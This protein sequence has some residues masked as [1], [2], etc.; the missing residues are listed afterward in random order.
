VVASAGGLATDIQAQISTFPHLQ[1]FD[2]VQAGILPTGWS[3]TRNVSPDTI[4]FRVSL[5]NP[6][7]PPHA[8]GS[9]NARV[10]Q[11]LIS[12]L[13]D[14]SLVAPDTLSFRIVRSST[15]TARMLV[16]ASI[17]SGITYA[18]QL[19]DSLRHPGVTGYVPVKL[20]LPSVL[21]SQS[22]VRF[23]WRIVGDPAAGSTA[24][25]RMDDI[26]VTARASDDLE[27]D[28]VRF[29]P[30]LPTEG[31][32]MTAIAKI[33]NLGLRSAQNF[34]AEFY[35]DANN[36]SLPQPVELRSVT[37]SSGSVAGG[38]SVELSGGLGIVAAG[39]HLAIVRLVYP[40][41]QNP[42]NNLGRGWLAVGYR[43]GSIVVNEIMYA[44]I[45]PEP[46]WL[47]L[48]NTRA[49]SISLR[50]WFIADSS[51][52][53]RR[54]TTQDITIPPGGYAVLTGNPASLLNIHP[55][56]PAVI[57]GVGSFP[58]L[59]NSG[60]AVILY[61]SRS[62]A[63]D[64][65]RYLPTW[66]GNAG[67]R[68]LERIDPVAPSVQQSNWGSC[69]LAERSTP[70]LRNSLTRKDSDL[71]V[72][73]LRFAPALPVVGESV[74]VSV[75]VRN[76]GRESI[77]NFLVQ[78][79]ADLNTDSL[80][81][82]EELIGSTQNAFPLPPLDSVG[83][84]FSVGTLAA[85]TR[86]FIG[87]VAFAGDEDTTNNTQPARLIVGYPAGAVRIN[88]I[89]YAPAAGVPEWVELFN[90]ST[91]SVELTRWILGNRSQSSRYE[92]G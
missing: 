75:Q 27:L 63:M 21:S 53:Q 15:H 89:M 6:F 30:S 22:S 29:H 11:S 73:T 91:D 12:P 44:P 32:S 81:Q 26:L 92:I 71:A 52:T 56:I 23:R 35:V 38:D 25:L 46:E 83:Y 72:D 1:N 59:N 77:P 4:D 50:N 9:T 43:P 70:G 58:S 3:S 69:R 90:A 33:R 17:D 54:I 2:S 87:R 10:S 68:S 34:A 60:D 8:V 47:E 74:T 16:E 88:E 66:G 28:S 84:D 40:P 79:F 76:P 57:I 14:F 65:V 45:S 18:A 51:R 36:D 24:T 78:L 86:S 49:D 62:F 19:G 85:G 37:A 42:A 48:F 64:S 82:P 5:T 31:D 13:F 41:D 7:S 20:G 61:D 80:P 67:G 55:D 39:S